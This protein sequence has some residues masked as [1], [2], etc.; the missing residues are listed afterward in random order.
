MHPAVSFRLKF[1]ELSEDGAMTSVMCCL[2]N[3]AHEDRCWQKSRADT[4]ISSWKPHDLQPFLFSFSAKTYKWK[5]M[6]LLS[7]RK[8]FMFDLSPW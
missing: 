8:I 1:D 5:I 3:V 7:I 2:D 4:T 6:E